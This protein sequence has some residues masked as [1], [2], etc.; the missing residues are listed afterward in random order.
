MEIVDNKGAPAELIRM[1]H[2]AAGKCTKVKRV[3]FDAFIKDLEN[4][5]GA[6][7]PRTETIIID[8]GH[9]LMQ[10]DW[11]KKGILLIPNVW[12]NLVFT[13]FHEMG[14]AF[15]LEE[16]PALVDVNPLPQN[17]EDEANTIGEDSL[18]EWAKKG[19]IP[20]LDEMN[21]VGDQ[22]RIILNRMYTQVPE[23]VIEEL[24][25]EGTEAVANALHLILATNQYDTKEDRA[26][27]FKDIDE[28]QLGTK[29]KG[30][31]Y[32]TAY[33]AINT[34]HDGH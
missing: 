28:G 9:C 33:E 10:R 8:M 29:V 32:F 4:K 18:L 30:K 21:W 14:H 17:Y 31:H 7:D 3:I 23:V 25:A 12:F 24:N 16:D 27:L 5:L 6:Y 26:K 19:I 13:F 22:L 34:N 2:E 20:R 15:Q 11:M 1:A